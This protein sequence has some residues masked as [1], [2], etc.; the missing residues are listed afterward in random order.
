[1][2]CILKYRSFQSTAYVYTISCILLVL[3]LA[4]MGLTFY[5]AAHIVLCFGSVVEIMLRTHSVFGY[6]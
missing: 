4:G 2:V 3:D 1:M 6:C 5:I